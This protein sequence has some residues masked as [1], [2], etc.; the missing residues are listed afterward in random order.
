MIKYFSIVHTRPSR[1][2]TDG[3]HARHGTQRDEALYVLSGRT[4]GGVRVGVRELE[5][6]HALPVDG[7]TGRADIDVSSR[8]SVRDRRTG[9]ELMQP[10]RGERTD[11]HELER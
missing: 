4:V 2:G 1:L 3:T 6:T 9:T 8:E 7:P 10:N 5:D 11:T